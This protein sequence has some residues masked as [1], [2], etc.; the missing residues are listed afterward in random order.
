[1]LVRDFLLIQDRPVNVPLQEWAARL[2]RTLPTLLEDRLCNS[3]RI[4]MCLN[5]AALIEAL[6]GNTVNAEAICDAHLGWVEKLASKH[7]CRI[8]H[9]AIQPWVN[10]GRL[11]RLEKKLDHALRHFSLIR[12]CMIERSLHLGP[13]TITPVTWRR[14]IE[15]NPAILTTLWNIYVVDSLNSYFTCQ[16]FEGA[17][18]FVRCERDNALYPETELLLEGELIGL[19]N[20]HMYEQAHALSSSY[21]SGRVEHSVVFMLYEGLSLFGLRNIVRARVL[22]RE[23]AAFAGATNFDC[24]SHSTTL[25]YVYLLASLLEELGEKQDSAAAYERGYRLASGV[26]DQPFC[27]RYGNAMARLCGIEDRTLWQRRR[28][29]TLGKC[30]YAGVLRAEGIDVQPASPGVFDDLLECI[31]SAVCLKGSATIFSRSGSV[32]AQ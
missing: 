6:R 24:F 1:M 2:L 9:L 10:K 12:D 7:D 3:A 23:L 31:S 32:Q 8:Y 15:D 16:D 30:Y 5:Q 25:R 14:I 28:A 27:I 19:I 22:A 18:N 13:C 17:L 4:A 11:R 20:T 29:N 26:D 21:S